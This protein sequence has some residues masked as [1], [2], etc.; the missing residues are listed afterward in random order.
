MDINGA[1][2]RTITAHE[3][4][5][6]SGLLS[7]NEMNGFAGAVNPNAKDKTKD[8]RELEWC[9]RQDLTKTEFSRA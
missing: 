3:S 2:L 9:R 6:N 4:D 8:D 1:K 7:K 5:F